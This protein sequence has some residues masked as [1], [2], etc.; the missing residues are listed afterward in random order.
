M[1]KTADSGTI[2]AGEEASFTIHVWNAGPGDA[3]NVELHDDL[4]PGLA[5][6]FEIVSGDAVQEDCNI[7]SSLV[8]GAEPQCRSTASSGPSASPTWRTAS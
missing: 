4:P 3:F 2:D 7:A 6:D 5:W 8:L 1:T